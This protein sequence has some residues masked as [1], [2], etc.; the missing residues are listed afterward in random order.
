MSW[1]LKPWDLAWHLVVVAWHLVAKHQAAA[2]TLQPRAQELWL[3]DRNLLPMPMDLALALFRARAGPSRLRQDREEARRQ[4]LR[5][6]QWEP[7]PAVPPAAALPLAV[8]RS[9]DSRG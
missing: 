3:R 5:L 8:L 6:D 1:A 2:G 9:A 4:L 7:E